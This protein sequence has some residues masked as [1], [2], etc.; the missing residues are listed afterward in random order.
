MPHEVV[1]R[2]LE[3][4]D[5]VQRHDRSRDDGDAKRASCIVTRRVGSQQRRY[6][7]STRSTT[8]VAENR[9]CTSAAPPRR[10]RAQALVAGELRQVARE[11]LGVRREQARDPC[12][13]MSRVPPVSMA[14]IGTPSA[15]ASISTRLSDSGPYDGNASSV[16]CRIHAQT[17]SRS[18]PAEHATVDAGRPRLGLERARSGPS[19]TTTSGQV[20]P[21]RRD[22]GQQELHA[23]VGRELAGV[24]HV[25]ARRAAAP[26]RRG[27]RSS[28]A[29]ST[30]FG[31]V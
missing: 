19:P 10:A 29:M 13:M 22:G 15:A 31:I 24:E 16:A 1:H 26:L 18:Q 3:P 25:R 8:E 17:S 20:E 27:P 28:A 21:A 6:T 7:C 30:G 11:R 5:A 2:S 23:F 4:A 14:A 9:A 12:W